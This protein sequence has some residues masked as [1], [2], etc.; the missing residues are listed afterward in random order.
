MAY[1][2]PYCTTQDVVDCCTWPAFAKLAATA[3]ARLIDAATKRV[4]KVCR[5]PYGFW[6]QT[7][8]ETFNGRN[9]PSLWLRCRPVVQVAAV[10][11]NGTALDNTY[12]TAWCVNQKTG[13]LVRGDGQ[14]DNRFAA[15][16]PAGEQNCVVTYF[17]GYQTLPDEIVFATALIVRWLRER[18]KVS[19]VYKAESLGDYSYTLSEE[20]KAGTLPGD[21]MDLLSDYVQ[22][23]AF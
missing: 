2:D 15:W 17:A 3:Q 21:I 7:V 13:R 14:D 19:G 5:R 18:G 8:T 10:T 22:D 1:G 11:I 23:D 20:G 6:Q 12:G 4:D 16:F 9:L